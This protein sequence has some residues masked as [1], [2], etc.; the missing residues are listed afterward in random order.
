MKE[1]YGSTIKDEKESG[2]I[3]PDYSMKSEV[4]VSIV[5]CIEAIWNERTTEEDRQKASM[6][7]RTMLNHLMQYLRG[8]G[9]AKE[10]ISQGI[11]WSKHL[12][13][14]TE[15]TIMYTLGSQ[16]AKVCHISY[17]HAAMLLLPSMY[18]WKFRF[19]EDGMPDS[20]DNGYRDDSLRERRNTIQ[21]I[22][23]PNATN[24]KKVKKQLQF[25]NRIFG[26]GVPKFIGEKK[27]RNIA[28]QTAQNSKYFFGEEEIY[29]I[30]LDSFQ[31]YYNDEGRLVHNSGHKKTEERQEFVKGL[32]Q[33]TLETLLLT[34]QFLDENDLTFFLGEGT[35]LGAVRHH[36]F[37]PWDDDVDILMPRA[38]YDRL[39]ELAKMGKIP[40]ELNFDALEN[41]DK[42]WVL[43]AKM[44]LV[45]ETDYIQDKVVPLSKCHGPY[46]DIFPLE[47]WPRP[48]GIKLRLS[49]LN[50]K[51]C[52]RMLF[53]KTGY[54]KATKKKLYRIILRFLC[55]FVS[56]RKIENFAIKNM[57]RYQNGKPKYMV[58]LCSYYPFYKEVFPSG[59]F[60]EKI[61]IEFEG[62][63]MPIPKEYDYVLKTIYGMKYDSIPP[64]TVMNMRQHAFRLKEED[65][66]IE[67]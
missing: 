67:T 37:I 27:L 8:E 64:Y 15:E 7:L 31:R 12:V 44:Q 58:N 59:C 2:S 21:E 13:E 54:S 55:L 60:K 41:N 25:I 39:V 46:V 36:G 29:N 20:E 6:H 61:M 1:L 42:H 11:S 22:I 65:E 30:Y 33:L 34:Q 43:G 17:G 40:P 35:L 19:L 49:D 5:Y 51:I 4:A 23:F 63:S 57:K 38:D 3:I 10:K 50:V 9:L 28:K 26:F 48:F 53:M 66:K 18:E 14:N 56:N 47:Y 62:H 52:R 45:R 16:L 24:N 32:Q